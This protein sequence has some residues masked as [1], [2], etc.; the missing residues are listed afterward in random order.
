MGGMLEGSY[1][2]HR[3]HK[4][5][6]RRP[7]YYITRNILTQKAEKRFHRRSVLSATVCVCVLFDSLI[8]PIHT[9]WVIKGKENCRLYFYTPVLLSFSAIQQWPKSQVL[10]WSQ[11]IIPTGSEISSYSLVMC[12]FS[13]VLWHMNHCCLFNPKSCFYIYISNICFVNTFSRYT[14]LNDQT[15]LFL[16]VQF[17]ISQQG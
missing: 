14:Q 2:L 6:H 16:I 7:Q 10:F 5:L 17:S 12:W 9:F 11:S 15:V 4:N 13:L 3:W 8:L 1:R